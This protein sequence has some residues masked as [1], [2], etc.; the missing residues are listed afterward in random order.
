MTDKATQI[1]REFNARVAQIRASV[2][3]TPEAK[4]RKI[5]EAYA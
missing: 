5:S 1:A 4:A 2:D 3:L